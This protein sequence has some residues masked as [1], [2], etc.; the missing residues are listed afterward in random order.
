MFTILLANAS[1]IK[2]LDKAHPK[3]AQI[4]QNMT[5]DEALIIQYLKGEKEICYVDFEVTKKMIRV[6]TILSH[7]LL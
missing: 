2:T 7:M 6:I 4:V 1:N 5:P 3:F